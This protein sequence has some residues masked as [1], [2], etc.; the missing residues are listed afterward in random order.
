MEP[1]KLAA[2]LRKPSG[3]KADEVGKG[4]NKSNARVIAAGLQLLGINQGDR[5][6][7]IGPGNGQHVALLM[8]A[9]DQ[10]QYV[11]VDWSAAMVAAAMETNRALVSSGSVEFIEANAASLPFDD[12]T[13]SK[14]FSV[15]TIYFWGN[16]RQQLLEIQRVLRPEGILCLGFGDRGFMEQLAFTQTGFTLYDEAAAR[17]L[18]ASGDF[19]VL[20]HETY[21]ETS[22]SN[23]GAQVEKLFHLMR[24]MPQ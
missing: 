4:M 19:T 8:E 24:C 7:E 2:Q 17:D 23:M 12:D 20:Q 15:N 6:L 14:V 11:G 9:A 3:L 21:E 16:P 1:A 22:T 18:L 10:I 13:F 5:I